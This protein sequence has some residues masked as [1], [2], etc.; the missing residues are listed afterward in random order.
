MLG[1]ALG[2]V[3]CES[4]LLAISLANLLDQTVDH[5][6]DLVPFVDQISNGITG[7]DGI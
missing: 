2:V 5:A 7:Q 1:R 6:T 4:R 3:S